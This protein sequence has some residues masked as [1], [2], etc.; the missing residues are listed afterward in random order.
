MTSGSCRSS[1][2]LRLRRGFSTVVATI[3]SPN[4]QRTMS[5]SCDGGV[6]DDHLGREVVRRHRRVAVC[7]VH[8]QRCADRTVVDDRLQRPVRRVVP[9]HEAHLHQ[10]PATRDLGVDDPA[11]GLLRGGQRLLAEHRLARRDG[12]QHVLLVRRSP[13]GDQYGVDRVVADELLA[14]GVHRAAG[15]SVGDRLGPRRVHV[16]SRR[17]PAAP[18]STV[19]SRRMW[20]CPIMPT[21]MT[22]TRTVMLILASACRFADGCAG[23]RRSAGRSAPA[24][25]SRPGT[26]PAR[27]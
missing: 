5:I 14:G 24:R 15:Q 11:A 22:P 3:S 25:R 12:R 2:A 21:P 23:S 6:G 27:R 20:S 7:A 9:A 4:I 13:R 17:P 8:Q 16:A 18:D 26:C 1:A 10:P 19:V